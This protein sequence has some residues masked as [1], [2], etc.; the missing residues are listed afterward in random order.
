MFTVMVR[1]DLQTAP[2]AARGIGAPARS[3]GKSRSPRPRARAH[4]AKRVL[5]ATDGR[6]AGFP[7]LVNSPQGPRRTSVTQAPKSYGIPLAGGRREGP[8]GDDRD[9]DH[10]DQQREE[11]PDEQ[12]EADA[13]HVGDALEE[14]GAEQEHDE[15]G[16]QRLGAGDAEAGRL[17]DQ[18]LEPE[19]EADPARRDQ[20]PR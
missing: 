6:P 9:A 5:S 16:P 12:R 15:A 17:V 13:A 11:Q 1:N 19:P 7:V 20:R 10:D 14:Q 3:P 18:A 8:A 2:A 4:V